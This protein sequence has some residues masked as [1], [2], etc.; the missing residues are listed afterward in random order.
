MGEIPH[1]SIDSEGYMEK[2]TMGRTRKKS[3][4]AGRTEY[5][6]TAEHARRKRTA[7]AV[8]A[9]GGAAVCLMLAAAMPDPSEV[10][11]PDPGTAVMAMSGAVEA[12]G[13]SGASSSDE[14]EELIAP[15]NTEMEEEWNFYDY[16][17][18]LFAGLISGQ[19]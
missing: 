18:E 14:R 10:R 5:A 17:G 6:E 3:N 2:I 12:Q 11:T 8:F 1:K 15:S 19:F 9:F 4:G 7:D 13:S 16:I